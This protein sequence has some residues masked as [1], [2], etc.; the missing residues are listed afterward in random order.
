ME[1]QRRPHRICIFGGTGFVGSHLLTRLTA[2]RHHLRVVT[3]NRERH[4]DLWVLPSLEMAEANIFDPKSLDEVLEGVDVVINLVGILNERDRGGKGFTRIHVDF[5]RRL[6]DACLSKG[7]RRLL[8]MSALGADAA[9]GMS[10]YQRTKG[11]G[12]NVAHSAA[13]IRVTSFRPSVIY[14]PGDSFFNRFASLLRRTPGIFPLACPQA[15]YAPVYVGDVAEAYARAIDNSRTYGQ[16]Y[17]LC[18]PH[19]YTLK[20]LVEFT[21]QSLGLKRKVVGLNDTLSRMQAMLLERMPGKPFSK[22]NYLSMQRDN[23][24]EGPF[25]EVFGITPASVES[26][27]PTYLGEQDQRAYIARLRSRRR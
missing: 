4:H 25:P 1:P 8:H 3:R 21:A 18:G 11:E 24:C 22:D 12:E 23:V 2:D 19:V 7:I 6:V 20:E 14:G 26:I 16:R 17:D 15:R 9:Y 5:P 27:V 10:H 13:S